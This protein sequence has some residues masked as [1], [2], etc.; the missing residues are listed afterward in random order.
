MPRIRIGEIELGYREWGSGPVTVVF[1]HGNLASK[2]WIELAAPRFPQ[3]IRTLAID[4][5]GCGD[6]DRPAADAE[7]ANYSIAQHAQDMRA[8]LDAFG[9]SFCHLATHSTGGIIALRMLLAEP[10]RFGRVFHLDPVAPRS[11]PFTKEHTQ[12]F[13]GMKASRDFTRAVMAHTAPSLFV[14]ESLTDGQ[15][16]RFVT[17]A[18]DRA[19]LFERIVDQTFSVSDGIW[20]GTPH[21]LTD[22]F[23]R[24]ELAAR[25]GEIPHPQ[26]VVWGERDAIIARDDLIAMAAGMPDCRLVTVPGIGHSLNVEAPDLYAGYFGGWFGGLPR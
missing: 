7:F 1:L 23:A 15:G 8:A 19:A 5:R 14:P 22:E 11:I 12:V 4:W 21:T 6:S 26:L 18:G 25:M 10:A 20:F 24:G 17:D 9:I 3:G 16:A 2:D 13:A